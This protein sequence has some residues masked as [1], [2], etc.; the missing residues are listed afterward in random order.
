VGPEKSKLTGNYYSKQAPQKA[1]LNLLTSIFLLQK[2]K[3]WPKANFFK[4][5][6]IFRK[7]F[8][9]MKNSLTDE[10]ELCFYAKKTTRRQNF[11]REVVDF[12]FKKN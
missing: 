12:L 2:K 5:I 9:L 7:R 4:Q 3:N 11:E 8:F 1:G 10:P 6:G